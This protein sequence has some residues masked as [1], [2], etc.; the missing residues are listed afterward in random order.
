MWLIFQ[1]E[2]IY[3]HTECS[4][5]IEIQVPS[6]CFSTHNIPII[7]SESLNDNK[8][9]L[10]SL[11]CDYYLNYIFFYL[12]GSDT[13]RR[14]FWNLWTSLEINIYSRSIN[15]SHF[16]TAKEL[17]ERCIEGIQ[18]IATLIKTSNLKMSLRETE[19]EIVWFLQTNNI[20]TNKK[21]NKK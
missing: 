2:H 16:Y 15:I 18:R 8:H 13:S 12:S 4:C 7:L 10:Y 9:L 1:L 6:S 14:D 17:I 20:I 3:Y 19:F 11:E 21:I 5:H